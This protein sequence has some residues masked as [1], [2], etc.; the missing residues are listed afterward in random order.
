MK[1][2]EIGDSI[3]YHLT[4][5][6]YSNVKQ[7]AV[8]RFELQ[9]DDNEPK[10]YWVVRNEIGRS[11]VYIRDIVGNIK[12]VEQGVSE[13]YNKDGLVISR[14]SPLFGK[15]R[16]WDLNETYNINGYKYKIIS[17]S[18]YFPETR[19]KIDAINGIINNLEA[20]EKKYNLNFDSLN[21]ELKRLKEEYKK[22]AEEK[23]SDKEKQAKLAEIK[24]KE[25]EIIRES[26]R[27]KRNFNEKIEFLEKPILDKQQEEYRR[28]KPLNGSL[29][30]NGGPGTGKTIALIQRITFLTSVSEIENIV[31]NISKT[32]LNN[33]KES[34]CFFSP[35]QRLENFLRN[36]MERE[37]LLEIGNNTE[38][39]GTLKNVLLNSFGLLGT[40]K[41]EFENIENHSDIFDSRRYNLKKIEENFEK[42]YCLFHFDKLKNLTELNEK[43]K[44]YSWKEYGFRI[45]N[46][47][48]KISDIKNYS[49]LFKLYSNF[50]NNF[51]KIENPKDENEIK[52]N[53]QFFEPIEKLDYKYTETLINFID[54]LEKS[55]I[56][57]FQILLQKAK[58]IRTIDDKIKIL[59]YIKLGLE[60]Y[61]IG[62]I[63]NDKL[64]EALYSKISEKYK[65]EIEEYETYNKYF[66]NLT[67]GIAENIFGNINEPFKEFRK[68]TQYQ[69]LIKISI[70]EVYNSDII[71]NNKITNQEKDLYL[72]FILKLLKK[73]HQD[74]E[75]YFNNSENKFIASYKKYCKSIIAVDEATDFSLTQMACIRALSNYKYNCVTLS[76]DLAQRFTQ[77]GIKSW[78][79][80]TDYT[81]ED[82]N[83]IQ[84]DLKISYRQNGTLTENSIKLYKKINPDSTTLLTSYHEKSVLDAEILYYINE[85][86]EDKVSWVAKRVLEI[87]NNCENRIPSIAVFVKDEIMLKKYGEAFSKN[88]L[89]TSNGIGTSVCYGEIDLGEEKKIRIFD[90]KHIKG[91]EFEALFMM[92]T[93]EI[94]IMTNNMLQ[95]LYVGFSRAYTYIGITCKINL[96][97]ELKNLEMTNA[98]DPDEN[99]WEIP[100]NS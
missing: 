58:K 36:A 81:G 68:T 5:E 97:D 56:E 46:E 47:I 45:I 11:H 28:A 98:N 43:I 10:T 62:L 77:N 12:T 35:S 2:I 60:R 78:K 79:E 30:I 93:D 80:Y 57:L 29:I 39:W 50:Q 26:E 55:D 71:V 31:S 24:E 87:K 16:Q 18:D 67:Q 72:L 44:N 54:E 21:N 70:K 13:V 64:N 49:D 25:E 20:D 40:G 23:A 75:N 95:Y 51:Q 7:N 76:G 3:I 74:T 41:N 88:K 37:R 6:V 84:K 90:I 8:C 4:N 14:E 89:L 100:V 48:N 73:I 92:D 33:L 9:I 19:Y 99:Y 69:S 38:V 65:F 32:E 63:D 53:K 1:Q 22:L 85:K 86:I 34:W 52:F 66:Y 96:P 82:L 83:D 91:L 94:L 61:W 17:F 27:K 59:R 15:I 42:F